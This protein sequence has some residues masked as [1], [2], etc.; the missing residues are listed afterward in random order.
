[1][2]PPVLIAVCVLLVA[3]LACGIPAPAAVVD[4]P[5]APPTRTLPEKS[6]P[7]AVESVSQYQVTEPLTVRDAPCI[8]GEPVGYLDTGTV[9]RVTGKART[10]ADGG[11]WLELDGGGWVNSEYLR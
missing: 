3:S 11:V 9:V 8:T 2:K 1:M 5:T 4:Q 6:A 10:C 7:V